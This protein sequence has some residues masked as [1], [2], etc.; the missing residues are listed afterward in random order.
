MTRGSQVTG[1]AA[2]S[3]I[4]SGSS[5]MERSTSV[6]RCTIGIEE[7]AVIA[8]DAADDDADHVAQRDADQADG[9]RD[10]RAVDEPREHVAPEPVGAEQEHR[11]RPPAGRSDGNRPLNRSQKLYSLAGAEEADRLRLG[12]V[13]R[14]FPLQRVHVE[15]EV[16][17]IDERPDEAPLVEEMHRLR[18]RVDEA[19]VAAVQ[20]VGRDALRRSGS[21]RS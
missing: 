16:E 14:V 2:E 21:S 11:A 4:Q 20:V 17:R 13:G 15:L 8:G 7:A 9:E 19:G 1:S 3:A 12:A 10:A 18:R 5:G 6:M